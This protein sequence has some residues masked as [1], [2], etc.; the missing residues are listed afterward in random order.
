MPGKPK[1]VKD[2][3]RLY[4]DLLL[5]ELEECKRVWFILLVLKTSR[6]KGFLGS[7]PSSSTNLG[8]AVY[9]ALGLAY[10]STYPIKTVNYLGFVAQLYRALPCQG[11]LCRLESGRGRQFIADGKKETI[12][13]NIEL[14]THTSPLWWVLVIKLS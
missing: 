3:A 14:L 7:N 4:R 1:I 13:A 2:E 9:S 5:R 12:F 6:P 11:R 10:N 8:T